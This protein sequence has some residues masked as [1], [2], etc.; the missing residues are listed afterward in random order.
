LIKECEIGFMF[1][2]EFR[3]ASVTSVILISVEQVSSVCLLRSVVCS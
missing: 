3:F 1:V 2:F